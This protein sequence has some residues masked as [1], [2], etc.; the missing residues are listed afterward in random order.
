MQPTLPKRNRLLEFCVLSALIA[1]FGVLLLRALVDL[2]DEAERL[3]VDLTIRNMNSGLALQQAERIMSGRE[4]TLRE[5]VAQ[6]PVDWLKNAPDG[7]IGEATCDERLHEGQWAWGVAR[8][9]LYY[10]PKQA[11]WLA[12]QGSGPC[13]TWRVLSRQHQALFRPGSH[14][15]QP[16]AEAGKSNP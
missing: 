16:A 13:L 5:L 2:Q 3:A 10:R 4:N 11:N 1:V 9:T 12:G 6:N 7:Y 14:R 8:K 15:L